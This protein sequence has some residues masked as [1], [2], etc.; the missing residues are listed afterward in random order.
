MNRQMKSAG[1]TPLQFHNQR[2]GGHLAPIIHEVV[3][4]ES[5]K[6]ARDRLLDLGELAKLRLG[7]GRHSHSF[8]FEK[9][10]GLLV[11]DSSNGVRLYLG[12]KHFHDAAVYGYWKSAITAVAN[13]PPADG[14]YKIDAAVSLA[15]AKRY[16]SLLLLSENESVEG[17]LVARIESLGGWRHPPLVTSTLR[18]LQDSYD[19]II[20]FN[21][22]ARLRNAAQ[23]RAEREIIV[24]RAVDAA[25]PRQGETPGQLDIFQQ[26]LI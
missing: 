17:A 6:A 23:A 10:A 20:V 24:I 18:F 7:A 22:T 26:P 15:Y 8:F 25:S 13:L 21:D 11:E 9:A 1:G 16:N 3:I 12:N 14:H 2:P 5:V 4:P 19:V